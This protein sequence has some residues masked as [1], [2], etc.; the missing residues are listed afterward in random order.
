MIMDDKLRD[1]LMVILLESTFGMLESYARRIVTNGAY[2]PNLVKFIP[3][4]RDA[5][6]AVADAVKR[7]ESRCSRI[8]G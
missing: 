4:D 8:E 5:L 1:D 7:I 3:A 2:T 6:E